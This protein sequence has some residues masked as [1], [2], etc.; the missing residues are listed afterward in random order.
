MLF[1]FLPTVFPIYNL[2]SPLELR[3]FSS[4]GILNE[5]TDIYT[6][7]GWGSGVT[8]LEQA[9]AIDV[10]AIGLESGEIYLHNLKELSKF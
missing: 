2:Y 4:F 1:I 9:P 7:T 8:I 3:I 6:D 10:L 5:V